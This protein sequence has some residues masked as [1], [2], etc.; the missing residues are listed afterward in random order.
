VDLTRTRAPY[1]TYFTE[2]GHIISTLDQLAE[3]L[4]R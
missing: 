3:Q 2:P 4:P 1:P